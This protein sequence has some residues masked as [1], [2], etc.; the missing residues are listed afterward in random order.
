MSIESDVLRRIKPSPEESDRIKAIAGRL[1]EISKKYLEEHGIDAELTFVGSFS[2]GTY[3]SNPDLDLFLLFPVNFIK[4]KMEDVCLKMGKELIDGKKAYAEHPYSSGFFEGLEVDLVPCYNIEDTSNLMTPVDRSPFHTK[5]IL[6][7]V[8]EKMDDEIRLL[9][10]FMK[11]IGTY[12]AEPNIRGFS[13]YLCELLTIHYGGFR[14]TL[15]AASEWDDHVVIVMEKKGPEFDK[16]LVLYDPVDCNRNV[17]SAVHLDTMKEFILASRAYLENPSE[18]FFF[19]NERK[20]L[21]DE[22]LNNV[23]SEHGTRLLTVKLKRPDINIDNIH[24]QNWRTQI[25]LEKKLTMCDFIVRSATH[26]LTDEYLIQLLELENDTVPETYK[27]AGPPVDVPTC[28]KFLEKWKDNP[29]G[30]PFMENGRWY[31]V[32]DRHYLTAK[33]LVIGEIDRIG[34]GKEID[35]KTLEVLNNDE[36]MKRTDK[37]MIT[38]LLVPMHKWEV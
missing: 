1:R 10:V 20:P 24:A 19:P 9:K 22:E 27:H 32:A 6:S 2:K 23:I 16:P 4:K 7:K 21:S 17:A 30:E 37:L 35:T 14:K 3:L 13:G 26:T 5:Y 18:K 33:D 12:G 28:E 15:E 25:G 36:T 8:D 31:V 11:G 29:H 38:E 34:I